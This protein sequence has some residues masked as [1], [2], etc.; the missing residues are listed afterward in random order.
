M[1]N[2][3]N[4]YLRPDT[5]LRSPL[6]RSRTLDKH[7]IDVED[8]KLEHRIEIEDKV[9]DDIWTSCCGIKLDKRALQFFSQYF[10]SLTLITFSMVQL[11]RLDNCSD[12]NTYLALLSLLI[13]I[14]LPSPSLKK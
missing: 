7:Y 1:D 14:A 8:K 11:I 10:I 9:Y 13:G 4:E 12:Q 5:A 6:S 3:E 2:N